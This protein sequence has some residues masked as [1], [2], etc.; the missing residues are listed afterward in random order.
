MTELYQASNQLFSRPDDECFPDM[1]TLHKHVLNRSIN[2][3][4]MAVN[5]REQAEFTAHDDTLGLNVLGIPMNLTQYSASQFCTDLGIPFKYINELPQQL[6]LENFN[7]GLSQFPRDAESI[8]LVNGVSSS[9]VIRAVTSEKYARIYDHEIVSRLMDL[10]DN[11]NVA[12]TWTG[13]VKG[14]YAGDRDMF[15]FLI[16]GGSYVTDGWGDQ[17]IHRGFF[18]RNS[19]VRASSLEITTFLHRGICGNH[20][21]WGAENIVR[22]SIRHVGN[23]L[24]QFSDAMEDLKRF[25]GSSGQKEEEKIR[26]LI[27]IKLGND[28][29]ETVDSVRK[30]FSANLIGKKDLEQSYDIGEEYA[31]VDGAPN[32]A[33][34]LS[35]AITRYSQVKFP[36]HQNKRNALDKVS[37]RILDKVLR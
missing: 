31:E 5:M 34:G 1:E 11:W 7:H 27:R 25:A 10:P 16:D 12:P 20:I 23:A 32:T 28:K 33:W 19:E 2:D 13:E 4:E 26:E 14:L 15:V 8:V 22:Q 35:N 18:V 21:V 36:N 37:G 24:E 17:G 9:P 6:A 30:M 3:I 29:E